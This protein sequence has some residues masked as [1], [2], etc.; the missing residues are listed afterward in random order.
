MDS[1]TVLS[2]T[3]YPPGVE[4]LE[5]VGEEETDEQ[6]VIDLEEGVVVDDMLEDKVAVSVVPRGQGKKEKCD[7]SSSG[8]GEVTLVEEKERK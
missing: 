1:P 6:T 3:K 2:S 7:F 4:M 8:G 5:R